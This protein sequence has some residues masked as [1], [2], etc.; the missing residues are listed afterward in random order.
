MKTLSLILALLLIPVFASA[1]DLASVFGSPAATP[2]PPDQC[3]WSFTPNP[4]TGNGVA[5]TV[6]DLKTSGG[7]SIPNV[8]ISVDYA[9]GTRFF[10]N[11]N[12]PQT[13]TSSVTGQWKVSVITPGHVCTGTLIAQ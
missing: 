13:V 4:F 6:I 2:T 9:G 11:V 5:T 10:F 1:T 12:Y 7:A 8:A 3:V